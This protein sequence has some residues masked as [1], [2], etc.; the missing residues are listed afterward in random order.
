M[1]NNTSKP[2]RNYDLADRLVRFHAMIGQMTEAIAHTK[3]GNNIK[4]Q[5]IRSSSSA[6]L[7]Y[8]EALVPESTPDFIHKI[9]LC[10]KELMESRIALKIILSRNLCPVEDT[11]TKCDSECSELIAIFIA[12]VR[13]AKKNLAQK[14]GK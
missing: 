14:R 8:G 11:I 2:N 4:N 10:L 9:S 5:L 6:A 7:N 12:S 3:E 13:T 1:E